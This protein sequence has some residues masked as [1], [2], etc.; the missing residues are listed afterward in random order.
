VIFRASTIS[1]RMVQH[2]GLGAGCASGT[3]NSAVTKQQH[4]LGKHD[5]NTPYVTYINGLLDG[6]RKVNPS[7]VFA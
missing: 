1:C 7:I 4:C 2:I 6:K 3:R 5:F